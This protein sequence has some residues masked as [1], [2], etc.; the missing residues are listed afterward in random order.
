MSREQPGMLAHDELA[1]ALVVADIATDALLILQ[2]TAG[3]AEL[4]SLTETDETDRR[5]VHQASGVLSVRLNV[6]PSDAVARLR[7]HAFQVG[8][9]H[10]V[11]GLGQHPRRRGRRRDAR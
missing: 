6:R 1:D 3:R 7:A 9:P 8:R 5:I 4:T 10:P 11:R 2:D